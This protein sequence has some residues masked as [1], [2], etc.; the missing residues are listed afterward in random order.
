MWKRLLFGIGRQP[1]EGLS[2]AWWAGSAIPCW[3][4]AIVL[5]ADGVWWAALF[6]PAAVWSSV[7]GYR[8]AR[9]R[10]YF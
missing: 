10:N 8:R 7:I 9:E 5:L 3:V 2:A 1:G 4:A 6:I